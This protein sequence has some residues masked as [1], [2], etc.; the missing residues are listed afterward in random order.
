MCAQLIKSIKLELDCLKTALNYTQSESDDDD[1][2][3]EGDG[4]GGD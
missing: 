2:E 3:G 1:G 4:E